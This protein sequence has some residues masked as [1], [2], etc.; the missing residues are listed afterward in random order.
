MYRFRNRLLSG[1]FALIMISSLL[2]TTASAAVQ[3]SAYLDAYCVA[4]TPDSNGKLVIT[5]DVTGVDYMTEIGAKTISVYESTNGK[6]FYW[7]KT[8]ESSDYPKMM[9]SGLYYY[10]DVLTHQGTAGR[11]YYATA[12]VYAGN[13]TGGDERYCDSVI[14]RAKA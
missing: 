7:V 9:G 14:K 8:Y 2:C 5:L 3:S 6:D 10:K 11:Y 1:I 4:M 12:C 13:S